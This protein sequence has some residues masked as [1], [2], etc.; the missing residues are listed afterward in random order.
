MEDRSLNGNRTAFQ[1]SG[2]HGEVTLMKWPSSGL[3][4]YLGITIKLAKSPAENTWCRN[5]LLN[6]CTQVQHMAGGGQK[7][8]L[9]RDGNASGTISRI[10]CAKSAAVSCGQSLLWAH[11]QPPLS[12]ISNIVLSLGW[13]SGIVFF[14]YIKGMAFQ[15]NFL[16]KHTMRLTPP[17]SPSKTLIYLLHIKYVGTS[18]AVM[19]TS[20]ELALN[21]A[22]LAEPGPQCEQLHWR[23]SQQNVW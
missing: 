6:Q 23:C 20:K 13:L 21:G 19:R 14:G 1:G 2:L 3:P 7:M 10:P 16:A 17:S 11:S 12:A 18:V 9:L 4:V 15:D 22:N 5:V 8:G